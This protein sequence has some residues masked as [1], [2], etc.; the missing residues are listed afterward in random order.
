MYHSAVAV[1][2]RHLWKDLDFGVKAQLLSALILFWKAL[3]GEVLV[4]DACGLF[5][6]IILS[7]YRCLKCNPLFRVTILV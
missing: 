4:R 7:Y 2:C 1:L 6:T 3:Q 5:T